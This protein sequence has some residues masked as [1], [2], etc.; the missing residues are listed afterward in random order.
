MIKLKYKALRDVTFKAAANKENPSEKKIY[1]VKSGEIVEV[2]VPLTRT[3]DLE[4]ID[5]VI[6]KSKKGE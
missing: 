6:K 1:E 3:D 4:L 2:P 5:E